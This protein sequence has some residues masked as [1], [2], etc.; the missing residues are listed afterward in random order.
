MRICDHP[1]LLSLW[2]AWANIKPYLQN[3]NLALDVGRELKSRCSY[4]NNFNRGT[5]RLSW[6]E[7]GGTGAECPLTW[8][9]GLTKRSRQTQLKSE[10]SG[11]SAQGL[12]PLL[13]ASVLPSQGLTRI[14]SSIWQCWAAR[15]SGQ[16][17]KAEVNCRKVWG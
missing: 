1:Q 8:N 9:P 12:M 13:L 14:Q 7:E 2:T 3:K 11:P 16:E 17:F 6:G 15:S 10:N 5:K 4:E